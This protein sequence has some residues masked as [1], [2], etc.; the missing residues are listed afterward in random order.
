[1]ADI[2]V[3]TKGGDGAT[4]IT[5]Y[6]STDI[7]ALRVDVVNTNGAGDTFAT[8]YMLAKLRGARNPGEEASFAASRAVMQPQ[9]CKPG[10]IGVEMRDFDIPGWG[11]AGGLY[12]DG[13]A[14]VYGVLQVAH[15]RA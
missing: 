8:A 1:M 2:F 10:C 11:S 3:V 4:E 15:L 5:A 14:A 12:R 6:G 13:M 7:P 9:Q